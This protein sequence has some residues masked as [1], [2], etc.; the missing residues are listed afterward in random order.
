MNGVPCVLVSATGMARMRAKPESIFD[1]INDKRL[2]KSD[3]WRHLESY[4]EMRELLR[5]NRSR[6][7]GNEVSIFSIEVRL[8]TYT[9]NKAFYKQRD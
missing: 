5:L 3:I 6:N 1:F 4:G 9:S 7:P 8:S 2:K